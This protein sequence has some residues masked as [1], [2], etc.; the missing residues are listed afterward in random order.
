MTTITQKITLSTTERL[1]YGGIRVRQNDENTQVFDVE[2]V[3]NGVMKPFIGLQPFFCLMAREITGQGVSEEKVQSYDNV[4]GTISYVVSANAMQMIGENEAY[5]SFRKMGNNGSWIEQFSTRSFNYI[6]E[7]SIYQLPFKDSNYW[8]TFNEIYQK[9]LAFQQGAYDSWQAY[10][11][12]VQDILVS[13]DPGGVLLQELIDARDGKV[14]LATRLKDDFDYLNTQNL[15]VNDEIAFREDV[16]GS[17]IERVQSLIN[18]EDFNLVVSTDQHTMIF[19]QREVDNF[20]EYAARGYSH[21]AN[22]EKFSD[23]VDVQLHNGDNVHSDYRSKAQ[24]VAEMKYYVEVAKAMKGTS[25]LFFTPGNHDDGSTARR[26]RYASSL[27]STD[28]FV[29]NEEFK[30]IF[31]TR[32]SGQGEIREGDSLYF[33]KDYP[34]K[35]VRMISLNSSDI[36]ENEFD[37]SGN[38]KYDRWGHHIFQQKQVDWLANVALVDIPEDYRTLVIAHA[39]LQETDLVGTSQD[40]YNHEIVGGILAAFRDGGSYSGVSDYTGASVEIAVNYSAQGIRDFVGYF[41]GHTHQEAMTEFNGM[42]VC[43]LMNG[44]YIP[45]QEGRLVDDVTEDAITIIALPLNERKVNLYGFGYA[46][47]REFT[48]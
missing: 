16:Y 8:V 48:Y 5:F 1:A 6:V 14:D 45:E 39:P 24:T 35:K 9:F 32:T 13:I 36:P 34:D 42:T 23:L 47:N 38:I 44:V 37:D 18:P 30:T 46:S 15:D 2:V 20:Y 29:T 28:E 7:K 11:N 21:L 40:Y 27:T 3:E 17:E 43:E 12:S 41:C 31:G 4:Q 19:D 22:F 33:Y 26:T 25:D 10:I